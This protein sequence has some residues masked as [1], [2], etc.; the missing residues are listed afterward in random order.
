MSRKESAR[1][2][3][4]DYDSAEP[5][6]V[7]SL[8]PGSG[9]YGDAYFD[10]KRQSTA[11]FNADNLRTNSVF[12]SDQGR[13]L[14]VPH[15]DSLRKASSDSLEY[16]KHS[17]LSSNQK[18]VPIERSLVRSTRW[19]VRMVNSHLYIT[20]YFIILGLTIF[21][22]VYEINNHDKLVHRGDHHI[23]ELPDWFKVLDMAVLVILVLEVFIRMLSYRPVCDFF[24]W[25]INVFDFAVVALCL[26]VQIIELSLPHKM[27]DNQ[28][29][30]TLL[31]ILRYAARFLVMCF[32]FGHNRQH[33]K[34]MKATKPIVF[35]NCPASESAKSR[36]NSSDPNLNPGVFLVERS[37]PPGNSV[38]QAV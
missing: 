31:I 4:E 30:D 26:A 24:K 21:L 22:L 29:L 20:F 1:P 7:D 13:H 15:S 32:L 9:E 5:P 17:L 33:R 19:N 8:R 16:R 37:P 27:K 28:W 11:F 18:N 12:N 3:L 36:K 34:R 10:R 6:R 14:S 23:Y 25:W 35:D 2:L 38:Q